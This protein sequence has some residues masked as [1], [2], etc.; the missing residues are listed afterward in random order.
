[1]HSENHLLIFPATAEN[2]EVR[3][4]VEPADPII[5]IGQGDYRRDF[6]APDMTDAEAALSRCVMIVALSAAVLC[7][8]LIVVAS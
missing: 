2:S 4:E 8:V 1:M 3:Y 5:Q 6:D 7:F